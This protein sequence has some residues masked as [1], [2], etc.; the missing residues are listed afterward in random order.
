MTQPVIVIDADAC[1]P[2]SLARELGMVTVPPDPRPLLSEETVTQLSLDTAPAAAEP[3][4]QAC[5]EVA[6]RGD[7]VLY[8]WSN[9]GFGAAPDAVP[10]ARR[11]V[12][13]R[14]PGVRFAAHASELPLMGCGWQAIAAGRALRAGQ[15][16][17][18]ACAAAERVAR[19]A[20][21]LALLEHP[22]LAGVGGAS[23]PVAAGL[24]ALVALRGGEI[25]VLARPANR[26]DGLIALR[27][28]FDAAVSSL[29]TGALHVAVLHAAAAPG[30][31]AL[32]TWI[33][34]G[35][36]DAEVLVAPIT[37]HAATR[38]G[39]RMIGVAWYREPE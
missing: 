31:E 36:V 39:P 30:A 10:L 35:Y 14:A 22:E 26:P 18:E 15:G 2:L 33:R 3:V 32:A 12:A 24:R 1:V 20:N 7:G 23:V 8:V 6:A 17:D 16:L 29:G 13:A 19:S 9:D 34:R 5:A 27:D 21:V 28:H 38:L 25:N 37:R 4:A 11:A